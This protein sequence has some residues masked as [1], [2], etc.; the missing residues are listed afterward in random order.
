MTFFY[1]YTATWLTAVAVAV[2]LV[3]AKRRR[4]AA[5][6]PRYWRF[7]FRPWKLVTF[8]LAAAGLI[9]IA[10]FTGD[11]TWDWV[12]ASF[13]SVGT[14]LTAPWAV[15]VFYRAARGKAPW[16]HVYVALC[17]AMLTASWSY[18]LY[19]WL[20]DGVYPCTWTA[21]MGASLGLYAGGGLLWNIDWQPGRGTL[22]FQDDRWP[23]PSDA[24]FTK[25]MWLALPLIVA[26]AV[27]LAVPFTLMR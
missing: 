24:P 1:I 18:D 22:A 17:A 9:V 21:N 23:S 6:Y 11:P 7:L 10:P 19:L 25:F 14:F 2:A 12:D 26:V 20:R 27:G 16:T 13:M 4:F 3:F 15:G 5:M 8:A